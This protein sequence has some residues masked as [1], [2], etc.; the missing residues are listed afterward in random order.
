MSGQREV[1]GAG[2]YRPRSSGQ[3]PVGQS[4][5]RR[6]MRRAPA[7]RG[8]G[9]IRLLIAAGMIGFALISYFSKKE[10]NEVTG[11]T[12]Y[13]ALTPEQEIALGLQA[14]PQ[15]VQQ[16]GG[17]DPDQS[18]QDFVDAVGFGLVQSSIARDTNWQ[19]EFHLLDDDE[20]VNAFA[21]PGG[22]VFITDALYNRL[23]TK[24][25]LAGVLGHEIGHVLARHSAQRMAKANL[26]RGVIGSVVIAAG[27]GS[28]AQIA[29]MIGQ[30]VNMKYGRNDELQSDKLGVFIMSDAGYDPNA[31]KGVMR[32]L[33]EASGGASQPEFMSTHPSP[34]NRIQ[35]IDA[36]IAERWPNGVP[37]GLEP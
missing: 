26:T 9:K 25:Q 2:G 28:E 6:P 14:L 36:A 32:I 29:Q 3:G 21:L 33:A 30:M 27:G 23:E 37:S 16:H 35:Q 13:I 15:M 19:F 18:L 7:R 1:F 24:G 8:Y 34:D 12:Q 31:L 11:E 5:G 4:F 22:Q 20:T 10:F 17:H